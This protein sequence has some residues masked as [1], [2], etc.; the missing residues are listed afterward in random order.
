ML[1]WIQRSSLSP[2]KVRGALASFPKPFREMSSRD[3]SSCPASFPKPSWAMTS[4]SDPSQCPTSF[5]RPS[6]ATTSS[7]NPSPCPTSYPKPSRVTINSSERATT[8][9]RGFF[10]F[11]IFCKFSMNYFRLLYFM[12]VGSVWLNCCYISWHDCCIYI[13]WLHDFCGFICFNICLG[14]LRHNICDI[15]TI[16]NWHQ[17]LLNFPAIRNPTFNFAVWNC[18]KIRHLEHYIYVCVC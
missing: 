4:S 16:R 6:R 9:F 12:V 1:P 17:N 15:Y 2:L 11:W 10:F 7:D 8:C 5:T 14:H 18:P 3:P 13:T